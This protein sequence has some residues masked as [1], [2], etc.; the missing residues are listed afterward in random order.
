MYTAKILHLF[1][2]QI[3]NYITNDEQVFNTTCFLLNKLDEKQIKYNK[4]FPEK[5]TKFI[6]YLYTKLVDNFSH[7][8][9]EHELYD[10]IDKL[11]NNDNI[12]KLKLSI[13]GSTWKINWFN[14]EL[15]DGVY[16]VQ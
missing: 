5:F 15:E 16:N 7:A 14:E 1:Q 3:E 9:I 2:G 13:Y 12:N 10:C 11:N 6:E 8:E 4:T